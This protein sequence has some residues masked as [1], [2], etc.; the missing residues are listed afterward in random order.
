MLPPFTKSGNDVEKMNSREVSQ[1]RGDDSAAFAV[2]REA[3]PK[4]CPWE[5]ESH[6]RVSLLYPGKQKLSKIIPWLTAQP[7]WGPKSFCGLTVQPW[8][9]NPKVEPGLWSWRRDRGISRGKFVTTHFGL[10]S[11]KMSAFRSSPNPAAPNVWNS[12]CLWWRL[13]QKLD[14]LTN[15]LTNFRTTK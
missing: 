12:S 10:G 13:S 5:A 9:H 14:P 1:L 8:G 11:R 7:S 15:R 3:G 2:T 4:D 6:K